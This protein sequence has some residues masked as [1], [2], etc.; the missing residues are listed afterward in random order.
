M[1]GWEKNAGQENCSDLSQ[2]S[3]GPVGGAANATRTRAG[4]PRD[5]HASPAR[6][7]AGQPGGG[8]LDA[9]RPALDRGI[10][11][12]VGEL[13]ASG[14]DVELVSTGAD[15]LRSYRQADLVLLRLDVPDLDG[16]EVCR[17][18]RAGSDIPIISLA[19]CGSELDRVLGLQA[20]SDDCLDWPCGEREL[21]ARIHALL[22]RSA[23]H[24]RG[25]HLLRH[26]ALVLDAEK[27]EVALDGRVIDMTRKE[28]DLLHLLVTRPRSVVP[29][30]QLLARVWNHGHGAPGRR[31]RGAGRT[32]DTHVSSL[33]GKLGANSWIVTV[34]GVGYRIGD[35]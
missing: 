14:F 16:L 17:R 6:R 29:R 3:V 22:R 24:G 31:E 5:D 28:F 34:H 12:V 4:D 13:R 2:T 32:L 30:D 15:A 7:G 10:G 11:L 25:S 9:A 1:V 8:Q 21:L 20:G 33:R 18:I 27:R 35:G 19:T 26:G 23:P